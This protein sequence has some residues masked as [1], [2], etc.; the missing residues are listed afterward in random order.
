MVQGGKKVA[1]KR[2]HISVSFGE[3]GLIVDV[4][5][6][7]IA[8]SHRRNT[9]PLAVFLYALVRFHVDFHGDAD[10]SQTSF[11]ISYAAEVS[12]T[13]FSYIG[14]RTGQLLDQ[15]VARFK[16]SSGSIPSV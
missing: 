16:R 1:S 12:W 11:E 4:G 6:A 14:S 8:P 5:E 15:A 2:G 3:L 10:I 13:N 7:Y 9:L